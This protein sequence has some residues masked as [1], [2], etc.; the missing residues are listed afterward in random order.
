MEQAAG[1]YSWDSIPPRPPVARF[2]CPSDEVQ[3]ARRLQ[4]EELQEQDELPRKILD[5][6]LR[7]ADENLHSGR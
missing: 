3:E 6:P 4:F 2:Q 5:R 7:R 1:E